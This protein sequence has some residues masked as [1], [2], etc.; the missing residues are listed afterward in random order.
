M[1]V[2]NQPLPSSLL[3]DYCPPTE[4]ARVFQM[5]GHYRHI[6]QHLNLH[7]LRPNKQVRRARFC[8]PR[9]LKNSSEDVFDFHLTIRPMW[10]PRGRRE[11]SCRVWGKESTKPLPIKIDKSL[12][13]LACRFLYC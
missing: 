5:E 6:T 9:P 1:K 11:E 4:Q 3:E 2:N 7:L 8:A 13:E 10:E 12:D